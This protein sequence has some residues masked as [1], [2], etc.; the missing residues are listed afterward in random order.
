MTFQM[1]GARV[2][3]TRYEFGQIFQIYS[4]NVYSGFFRD[5]SFGE[6]QGRYYISF[7]EEA[8]KT[9]LI[10]VE[11]RRLGSDRNLFVATT[12]GARGEPV[13]IV[14]SEKIDAFAERLKAEIAAM[15]EKKNTVL[16][17]VRYQ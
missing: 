6:I 7:R 12:P 16:K 4:Q 10:T 13:E 1:N 15:R 14:R 17:I 8:G 3:Y 5:F 11:K 9:P 2:G